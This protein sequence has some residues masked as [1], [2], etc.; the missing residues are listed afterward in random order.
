[1]PIGLQQIL[2]LEP[3]DRDHEN[4]SGMTGRACANDEGRQNRAVKP[5]DSGGFH[6]ISENA[7]A[8]CA[9]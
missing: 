3:I 2:W 4:R 8:T 9:F 7:E 5:K 6:S 1:M